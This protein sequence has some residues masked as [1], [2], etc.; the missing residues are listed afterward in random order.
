MDIV[1]LLLKENE[2]AKNVPQQV[3]EKISG[4]KL[5]NV[6]ISYTEHDS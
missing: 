2:G 1:V 3:L 6:L 4:K 5:F